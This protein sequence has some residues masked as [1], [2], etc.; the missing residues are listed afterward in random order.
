MKALL[1][2]FVLIM[3]CSCTDPQQQQVR[4][5]EDTTGSKEKSYFPVLDYIQSEIRVVDSLPVGIMRYTTENGKTDSGYIKPLEFDR[6]AAE[7]LSPVLSKDMFEREF[8]EASFFDNT[9]QFSSFVYSTQNTSL[10]INRVDV[11]VKAQDVVYNKVQSIY[12]EKSFL[13]DDSAFTQKM[14]W[15][16]GKH[17]LINSEIRT[18][19]SE[20]ITR[21][22]KV[23]WNQWD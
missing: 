17:F 4:N 1:S 3:L 14:F 23:V 7:F 10:P 13:K 19:K 15:K 2:G 18:P 12:M 8:T 5:T 11:V 6:L 22:V 21:Q 16:A 9:T 20:T